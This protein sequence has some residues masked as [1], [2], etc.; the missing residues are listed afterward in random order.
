MKTLNTTVRFYILF[1]ILMTLLSVSANAAPTFEM[2]THTQLVSSIAPGFSEADVDLAGG[3]GMGSMNDVLPE[4][5]WLSNSEY[6]FHLL[7][8][9]I[10]GGA[11]VMKSGTSRNIFIG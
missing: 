8:L 2:D 9:I 5:A 10:A 7:I 4:S 1:I 6:I 11:I 3:A